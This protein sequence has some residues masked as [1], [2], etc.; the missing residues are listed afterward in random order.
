M[1]PLKVLIIGGGVAGPALAHWLSYI[2]ANITLIE[3]SSQVRASGQQV[4]I[5]A[6]GVS[7][8]KKIGI[9]TAVS[10][11]CSRTWHTVR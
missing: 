10:R 5:R 8:M 2:G 6:Q 4:D 1:A 11:S 9:E 3:R 7:M